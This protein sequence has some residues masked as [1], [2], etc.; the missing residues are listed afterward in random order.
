MNENASNHNLNK[1]LRDMQHSNTVG[2]FAYAKAPT[3]KSMV[4]GHITDTVTGLN[5]YG[6]QYPVQIC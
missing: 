3:V 2:G 4:V 5:N 6:W 1:H